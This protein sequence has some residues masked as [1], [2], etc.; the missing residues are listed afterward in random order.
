MAKLRNISLMLLLG[1]SLGVLSG[2]VDK[3]FDLDNY[4]STSRIEVKDLTLPVLFNGALELDDVVEIEENELVRYDE[5]GQFYYLIQ[6]GEFASDVIEIAPIT[7]AAP[8]YFSNVDNPFPFGGVDGVEIPLDNI[9]EYASFPFEFK[10]SEVDEYIKDIVSAE[11][12]LDVTF[13]VNT[14]INCS[15]TDLTFQLPHGMTGEIVNSSSRGSIS[16]D[17]V[18]VFPQV[19]ATNGTFKFTYRVEKINRKEAG[20]VFIPKDGDKGYFELSNSIALIGG[21]MT[22]H[23]TAFNKKLLASVN[24]GDVKVHS[25]DGK[26]DYKVEDI[27]NKIDLSELPEILKDDQT[28]IKLENPQFYLRLDNPFESHAYTEIQIDQIR[29]GVKEMVAKTKEPIEI[30][31]AP[32]QYFVLAGKNKENGTS[33]YLPEYNNTASF[34]QV[35][36]F[37]EIVYGDG[38][39]NDGLEFTFNPIFDS[40][41]V[42]HL[43]IGEPIG[44]VKGEYTFYAPL[45]FDAGS[46]IVYSQKQTGWDLDDMVITKFVMES[47]VT[48][49]LTVNVNLSAYP[50]CKNDKGEEYVDYGVKI[51]CSPI[52][53]KRE[54]QKLTIE[55][56]SGQT[57]KNLT[58]MYYTVKLDA[59][60]AAVLGKHMKLD[61][62]DTVKITVSGYYD[63]T[64]DDD[65]D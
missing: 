23:E 5:N 47:M 31:S 43:P 58:G 50:I 22:A 40:K 36:G 11:I 41:Y 20:G 42:T 19:N 2:C 45:E 60:S 53:A 59:A 46:Q 12:E 27:V 1:G 28:K 32:V 57:V 17:N 65:E 16:A 63:M 51:S 38:I 26:V 48:S 15:F 62:D 33:W 13:E 6:N 7:A 54:P 29:S 9:R 25:I 61:F 49:S 21:T 4:D 18:L 56:E 10:F 55:M 30:T 14:G 35:D 8:G 64:D 52:L 37:G 39:P 34:C 24:I 44:Q 3:S